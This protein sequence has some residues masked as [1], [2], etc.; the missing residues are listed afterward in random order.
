MTRDRGAQQ[1][2]AAGISGINT[3]QAQRWCHHPEAMA[4]ETSFPGPCGGFNPPLPMCQ[5]GKPQPWFSQCKVTQKPG[6]GEPGEH[7]WPLPSSTS[8]CLRPSRLGWSAVGGTGTRRSR[9]TAVSPGTAGPWHSWGCGR[10]SWQ[11]AQH[12]AGRMPDA[13]AL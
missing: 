5:L 9:A 6:P 13:A 10:R 1:G 4:F 12:P 11:Q 7:G 3:G 2:R 8:C